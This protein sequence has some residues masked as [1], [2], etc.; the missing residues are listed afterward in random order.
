MG[1]P[2][3]TPVHALVEDLRSSARGR[4]LVILEGLAGDLDLE[5][6]DHLDAETVVG[7]DQDLEDVDHLGVAPLATVDPWHRFL[8]LVAGQGGGDRRTAE[9]RQGT[10][11]A[12]ETRGEINNG[13]D[14]L[15]AQYF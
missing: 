7:M 1:G 10:K 11:I 12:T 4:V 3:V 6:V 9:P 15:L 8:V 13:F 5:G 2:I 14:G